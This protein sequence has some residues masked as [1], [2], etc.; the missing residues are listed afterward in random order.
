M[1]NADPFI[2]VGTLPRADNM[3]TSETLFAFFALCLSLKL[4]VLKLTEAP[5]K[6][7]LIMQGPESPSQVM[8]PSRPASAST[9]SCLSSSLVR[10]GLEAAGDCG[11]Y[12]RAPRHVT[13]EA[14]AP[15]L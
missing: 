4:I 14:S 5:E 2:A 12:C 11:V 13:L 6:D 7:E 9:Y 10:C 1:G 15:G 8:A 3:E